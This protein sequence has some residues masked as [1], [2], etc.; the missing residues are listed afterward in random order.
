MNERDLDAVA[1]LEATLQTFPWSRGNF[2]D[3]LTAGYSVWVLR[4]G[5][6]LIGFSVVM[7]VIDEAHLLTIGICKRYQ[8]QG[9]GARMLRHAMECARLGGASKLFLEVRPSNERAVE[10]Y[11]H[12]GFQQIGLRKGYY[13]AVIGR[14][15]ALVFDKELA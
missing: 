14:E 9:Y 13:P 12:F 10:L 6:E 11:R 1:A 15:D 5:G 8:G 7:R 2:A 3:S 4:V